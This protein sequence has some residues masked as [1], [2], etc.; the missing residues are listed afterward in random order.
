[1]SPSPL[2]VVA[3]LAAVVSAGCKDAP[4]R[5]TKATLQKLEDCTAQVA[6]IADKD[7]LIAGYEAEIARLKLAGGDGGHRF[8]LEGDVW[9]MR[10][11]PA[12]R[13]G[14]LDDRKAAALANEFVEQ[15]GRARPLVQRCYVQALKSNA[16]L[17]NRQ[18]SLKVWATFAADGGFQRVDF[19]PDLGDAFEG[20]MRGVAGKWRLSGAGA[21]ATFEA[22]VSLT[23][24]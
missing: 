19:S 23:P 21:A 18:V 13:A 22:T 5:D 11:K 17:Q 20:C 10:A 3:A 16:S 4:P 6:S 24:T 8:V 12:G 15:V 9:A 2:A 7:R 1:M 14:G